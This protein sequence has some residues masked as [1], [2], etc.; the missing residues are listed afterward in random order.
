LKPY[1]LLL[2]TLLLVCWIFPFAVTAAPLTN[3]TDSGRHTFLAQADEDNIL[4]PDEAFKLSVAAKDAQTLDAN[5]QIAPGHYLY[6]DRI[7]FEIKPQGS[8]ISAVELPKGEPKQDP[9]FGQTEVFHQNFNAIINLAFAGSAPNKVTLLATYQG[10][11]EKGL[12]YSPIHKTLEVDLP[13]AGAGLAAPKNLALS[14]DSTDD[15]Q[16]ASLLKSGKL[17]LI[18]AGF[19]GFGLLL[20]LTPCMLPMIPILSG[21]IVGSKKSGRLHTFNLSLAYTMGMTL[22]YTLAGIAAGL[23]GQLLSNALQNPWALGSG[24]FVFVLLALSMFGFY[25]LQLPSS[26][27]S[28]MVNAT[29]HI[30]GGRFLGVFAMG[31]LSALIVSPCVA[32]PLAGALLYISKTHDVVLG[33]TALFALSLGMGVPLLL[34]GA[35]AGTLLPKAGPWM[36]AVSNFFGVVMLGMAIWLISPLIPAGVGMALWA[37]L[38]IVPAIYMH[39]LDGLPAHASQWK[40]FWKGVAVI[41]LL[42]G[43]ALLIGAVSG[44]KSPWQPLAGLRASTNSESRITLPFHRVKNLAD[45]ESNIKASSGKLVMLDF[46]A[47]WCVACKEFEQFTFS[48]PRVQQ[49]L[50]NVVLLQADVT[51]NSADDSALLKRFGLF[52]P[53]GIIFFDHTGQEITQLKVVGYQDADKFLVTLNRLNPKN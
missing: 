30:K 31:A 36:T 42:L 52:G 22:S 53:P 48:D 19:F 5:F 27:E 6:R 14:A 11:S 37:A 26:F 43:V 23:S 10:C 46:Y 4:P 20:S 49:S 1:L 33:G 41:A 8:S 47:D 29:N 18:I 3:Q 44:A 24:A 32:A 40:K 28:R 25:E 21:I 17:W 16:A 13:A 35:S 34:I 50:A 15:G 39:A 9:N 12:C 45:L 38:L 7:K 2:R 51:Q